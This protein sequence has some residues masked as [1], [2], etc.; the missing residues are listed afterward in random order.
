[1]T[2]TLS[3]PILLV[4]PVEFNQTKER[5]VYRKS[6]KTVVILKVKI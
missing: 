5:D 3:R 1:V 4:Y 2:S 6:I